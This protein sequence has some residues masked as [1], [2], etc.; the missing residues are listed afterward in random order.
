MVMTSPLAAMAES[1]IDTPQ[2]ATS[3]PTSAPPE[4]T[5]TYDSETGRWNTNEWYY[6]S[7]T[8]SYQAIAQPAPEPVVA[9]TIIPEPVAA[10]P[11]EPLSPVVS[12]TPVASDASLAQPNALITAEPT[13]A[14]VNNNETV[15][16][17]QDST[18]ST[19]ST[20]Q[21]AA[22]NNIDAL[23]LTGDATVILNTKAGD[24]TTG[25]ATDTATIINN[26]SSTLSIADNQNAV[27]FV[28]NVMGDVNGDILLQPMILKTMLESGQAASPSSVV[29][30]VD[31]N[32]ALTNNVDLTA[33]TGN[34]GVIGNTSAGN[35]TSGSANTVANIVNI[36]NSMVAANKS[37]VGTI[38]IY[39]NLNG[40]ILVAP[41]FIPQLIASNS[42]AA[43]G[44][45][46]MPSLSLV[47]SNSVQSIVNN[48]SLSAASGKASVLGN[49]SAG[50]ALTGDANTNLVIFNL[51]GHEV[52]ASNSLLVFVNVLGQW[53]GVIVDAPAGATAAA[54]GNGVTTNNVIT[55]DLTLVSNNNNQ[56]TNNVNLVSQSGNATVAGNT[57]AGDATTGDASASANIVNMTNSQFGLSGWFGILFINVF[58]TWHGSFGLDTEYGN[59]ITE[60]ITPIE[61]KGT[62]AT[63][64]IEFI[65]TTIN[66]TSQFSTNSTFASS[67]ASNNTTPR[68]SAGIHLQPDKAKVLG[69]VADSLPS[70]EGSNAALLAAAM[71][72][73]VSAVFGLN[74]FRLTRKI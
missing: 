54:I 74:K 5:Y 64:A 69:V 20:N 60:S 33:V 27:S 58:G 40:D 62:T 6:D 9:P 29:A 71:F 38:N 35:A 34:A 13:L 56:I 24:A 16:D 30:N 61:D 4:T 50:S 15:V 51:S 49:T 25:N 23:A 72:L 47:N 1:V 11:T 28:Q 73:V 18:L 53:V 3:T 42:G 59:A 66:T 55:P 36:I 22:T 32:V 10:A 17:Q 70:V 63:R 26:V 14:P 39:G 44:G 37:F 8:G 68:T 67:V 43:I 48:I 19:N 31:N 21:I 65:P 12:D 57:K 45:Q 7:A 41:D 2:T 52:I 46:T